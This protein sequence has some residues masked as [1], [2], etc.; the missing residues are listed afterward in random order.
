[1]EERRKEDRVAELKKQQEEGEK[2]KAIK[3]RLLALEMK[4]REGYVSCSR[5]CQNRSGTCDWPRCNAVS[6]QKAKVLVQKKE[7]EAA[8]SNHKAEGAGGGIETSANEAL[9]DKADKAPPSSFAES[10]KADARLRKKLEELTVEMRAKFGVA[11]SAGT[12]T[13]V[14][15]TASS[16]RPH[17]GIPTAPS[18]TSGSVESIEERVRR[19]IEHA[20]K[21]VQRGTAP[22]SSTAVDVNGY[23]V[24]ATPT[25]SKDDNLRTLR[26]TKPNAS[27]IN[28]PTCA[29]TPSI[30]DST[31]AA[32]TEESQD[33]PVRDTSGQLTKESDKLKLKVSEVYARHQS[34][35][36]AIRN[37]NLGID[38]PVTLTR[39]SQRKQQQEQQALLDAF[40]AK[41]SGSSAS[42]PAAKARPPPPPVAVPKADATV[43][44]SGDGGGGGGGGGGSSC[45]H[46][47]P[48][49]LHMADPSSDDAAATADPFNFMATARRTFQE[50]TS[51]HHR[52]QVHQHQ[53]EQKSPS[54][55]S[56]APQ[57]NVA[58]SEGPLSTSWVS[59]TGVGGVSEGANREGGGLHA[60]SSS[61]EAVMGGTVKKAMVGKGKKSKRRASGSSGR[62]PSHS[63]RGPPTEQ[64]SVRTEHTLFCTFLSPQSWLS[65]RQIVPEA[66]KLRFMAE[67]NQLE[68]IQHLENQLNKMGSIRDVALANQDA[69]KMAQKIRVS[70]ETIEILGFLEEADESTDEPKQY[71]CVLHFQL[72][73]ARQAAD[74][75]VESRAEFESRLKAE[76]QEILSAKMQRLLDRQT[77][78]TR[79]TADAARTLAQLQMNK[80]PSEPPSSSADPIPI[81]ELAKALRRADRNVA[82]TSD[83]S[84]ASRTS[85]MTNAD[86]ER[87]ATSTHSTAS[88]ER[89][90]S[91]PP[92]SREL[93]SLISKTE[94]RVPEIL[95]AIEHTE[96]SGGSVPR[97][98]AEMIDNLS[99][100]EVSA[101]HN[102]SEDIAAELT[103]EQAN[104]TGTAPGSR[105]AYTS[106]FE[107]AE[108]ED[109]ST[110]KEVSSAAAVS[111]SD[112][113]G[114]NNDEQ[115]KGG[116]AEL[117]EG[118]EEQG[119]ESTSESRLLAPSTSTLSLFSDGDS[120]NK[121]TLQMFKRHLEEESVRARHQY[122]LLKEKEASLIEKARRELEDLQ[123]RKNAAGVSEDDRQRA[124]RR[125]KFILAELKT[126]R[127]E[128]DHLK[129]SLKVAEKERSLI[130]SQ[131]KG[132]L[133]E[134]GA[135]GG[136][137][138]T[139][140]S[141]S[142]SKEDRGQVA[143]S[144]SKERSPERERPQATRD[145]LRSAEHKIL[146][147]LRKMQRNK[148]LLGELGP[149]FLEKSK[150]LERLLKQSKSRNA[151]SGSES[152]S[153]QD[154]VKSESERTTTTTS[155]TT[156]PTSPSKMQNLKKTMGAT[157]KTPLS[158][159]GTSGGGGGVGR[160]RHSSADS[161][162]SQS[163][164]H[165]E[166]VSD[167][168]DVEIR[169]NVL[170]D[171]L[172][173][174]MMT[175]AKLKKQ[176]KAKSKEKLRMKEETLKRQIEKYDKLIQETVAELEEE[177]VVV[178]PQIKTPYKA[179][180]TSASTST[181]A[182]V[183]KSF[184]A[185]GGEGARAKT[186]PDLCEAGDGG[187]GE[188]S[189]SGPAASHETSVAADTIISKED[190]IAEE[191]PL[192]IGLREATAAAAAATISPT[193][194]TSDR[195]HEDDDAGQSDLN[196]S[197]DFTSSNGSG[198]EAPEPPMKKVASAAKPL[199]ST[200]AP[201][202]T[203]TPTRMSSERGPEVLEDVTE[204][205]KAEE[206]KLAQADRIAAEI[207][208]QL[209]AETITFCVAVPK[210][211][212]DRAQSRVAKTSLS[213]RSRPQ[214]L[215]LTT[216]DI[217]S[218]S[219]DEGSKCTTN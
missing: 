56:E 209:L 92:V 74:K 97:T 189:G 45:G 155:T 75:R 51:M 120:F 205:K 168:S 3:T 177:Q 175:A 184:E 112:N 127:A 211:K 198:A 109:S 48:H 101:S 58:L 208:D 149:E 182:A 181:P 185:A 191:G 94:S 86:R 135:V 129:K 128:I 39:R 69:E 95:S 122:D 102:I 113:G 121:F 142:S 38:L 206:R 41:R 186:S 46:R 50:A 172:R 199:P 63:S 219:S 163:V 176:Q 134:R 169:I 78:A 13:T 151:D 90:A 216:F 64:K 158:P 117:E 19:D 171:E 8:G 9:K 123:E 12:T 82:V 53:Q 81:A 43:V 98:I 83:E 130:M 62:E 25:S 21:I 143:R 132:L 152:S 110:V 15:A 18:R 42:H 154:E 170:Q 14:A 80:R 203:Q 91:G 66:L 35:L 153:V 174:R 65:L 7:R 167:H 140:S 17:N 173:R 104:T 76:M 99:A 59:S 165:S 115:G 197:D 213:P 5:T 144:K 202:P 1:M 44:D 6:F 71:M 73:K 159:K 4:R 84:G 34:D 85:K 214:D 57:H 89:S 217:S 37:A 52:A 103:E 106:K 212:P 166:T 29:H 67:L 22:S 11:N 77:E 139:S 136:S 125:A 47:S 31:A 148:R 141:S 195:T 192:K 190:K 36:E 157:L 108:D 204:G 133:G 150:D 146:H 210:P 23:K 114:L 131:Q 33:I 193:K 200:T 119:Y 194:L 2:R 70:S 60:A 196:Y 27:V 61:A 160:K 26:S 156:A 107:D 201:T 124:K 93:R 138:S 88:G 164:S 187:G 162:D 188:D 96:A 161:D 24:E 16:T 126:R 55:A 179:T 40:S 68:G 207:L 54:V 180:S 145:T 30:G 183:S 87:E 49:K 118:G 105:E 72:L 218:E 20:Q 111:S 116:E 137:S 28:T 10:D 147:G 32:T 100:E 215:M 178:Q 79:V